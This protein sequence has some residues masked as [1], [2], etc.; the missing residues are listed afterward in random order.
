MEN[1]FNL[2]PEARPR[3][4]RIRIFG[5]ILPIKSSLSL[6]KALCPLA[7]S[8]CQAYCSISQF[9][10][11]QEARRRERE[12]G[13]QRRAQRLEARLTTHTLLSFE[14][15]RKRRGRERNYRNLHQFYDGRH[16][17]SFDDTSSTKQSFCHMILNPP[18][19]GRG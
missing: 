4:K 12:Q 17:A 6:G 7:S 9:K 2:G 10:T 8:M 15:V 16:P 3:T 11:K 1:H 14:R 18:P 5:Q 19:G 13:R